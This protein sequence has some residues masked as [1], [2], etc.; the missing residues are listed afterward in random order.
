ME[1]A[2]KQEK[3]FK[4]RCLE[5][6]CCKKKSKEDDHDDMNTELIDNA[7]EKDE[8]DTHDGVIW[9]PRELM[10]NQKS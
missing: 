5:V 4:E 6:M 7:P 1:K 8:L 10:Q 9:F 3:K 2:A